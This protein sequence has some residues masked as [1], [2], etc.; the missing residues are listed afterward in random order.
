MEAGTTYYYR[1]YATNAMGTAY[2]SQLT[3]STIAHTIPEVTTSSV[4]GITAF[5]AISGG[6][7][8]GNGGLPIIDQGVCWSTEQNPTTA[9]SHIAAGSPE[10]ESFTCDITSL[11]AGTTYYVRAY[12][13]NA[14]G[15]G[16]GNTQTFTTFSAPSGITAN[17]TYVS[18][19][20][21]DVNGNVTNN[22]GTPL[23]ARGFCWSVTPSPTLLDD[24]LTVSGTSTGSFSGHITGLIPGTT[25]TPKPLRHQRGWNRLQ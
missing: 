16:Y 4:T 20:G 2:G 6:S 25:Y 1:A 8:T 24:Y 10:L 22:G 23:T 9:D 14:I 17:Y 21:A 7:V 12:A 15:T 3:F 11:T 5:S 13:V 19:T 18:N